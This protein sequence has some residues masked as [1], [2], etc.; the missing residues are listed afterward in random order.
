MSLGNMTVKA[1]LTTA[2]GCLAAVVLVVSALAVRALNQGHENY[3]SYVGETG[4]RLA[5]AN[6]IL[7]ATNDRAVAARNLVLVTTPADRESEK[8]HVTKAHEKVTATFAKLKRASSSR[9]AASQKS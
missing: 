7:D 8:A 5:L 4:V 3:A 6:D 1:K 2:F 9:P